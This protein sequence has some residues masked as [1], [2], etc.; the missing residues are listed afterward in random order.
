MAYVDHY[1][2]TMP[3]KHGRPRKG[4]IFKF[5]EVETA[6]IEETAEP[7][8]EEALG[9]MVSRK[10]A[11]EAS[12]D[13]AGKTKSAQERRKRSPESIKIRPREGPRLL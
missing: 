11:I 13:V 2:K 4:I 10:P 1:S 6:A 8:A 5:A 12:Q 7:K 9:F 3:D